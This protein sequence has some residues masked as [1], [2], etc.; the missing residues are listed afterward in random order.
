MITEPAPRHRAAKSAW[1]SKLWVRNLGAVL[2]AILAVAGSIAV[3]PMRRLLF[4]DY[5]E[6]RNPATVARGD[7]TTVDGETWKLVSVKQFGKAPLAMKSAPKGT[8]ITVVR[9]ERTGTPAMTETCRAYLVEGNRRWLAETAFG[10]Q[11]WVKP[12]DDGT[13]QDCYKPGPLQFSFLTPVDIKPS[14]V[15]ITNAAGVVTVRVGL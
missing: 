4:T 8:E 13:T 11:Y 12:P 7:T 5:L 14:A 10:S 9:I 2:I 15:E 1:L 6:A 3:D